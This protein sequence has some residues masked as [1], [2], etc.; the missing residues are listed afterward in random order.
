MVVAAAALSGCGRGEG[1][2]YTDT[3]PAAKLVDLGDPAQI[4]MGA[5]AYGS[6][7]FIVKAQVGGETRLYVLSNRVPGPEPNVIQYSPTEK[8]FFDAKHKHRYDISGEALH[9]IPKG[10]NAG[11]PGLPMDRLRVE[12]DPKTGHVLLSTSSK[13]GKENRASLEKKAYVVVP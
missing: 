12:L 11:Q 1:G 8:T 2:K 9:T 7:A 10:P 13:I 6:T 4:A 5:T 3:A